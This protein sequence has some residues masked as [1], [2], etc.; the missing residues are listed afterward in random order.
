M[1][2]ASTTP[3]GRHLAVR[4]LSSVT[5]YGHV[6]GYGHNGS[7]AKQMS[8]RIEG[9]SSE[10][11]KIHPFILLS[12]DHVHMKDPAD[13]FRRASSAGSCTSRASAPGSCGIS[14]IGRGFLF[15]PIPSVLSF[16]RG[17]PN[18][19][20]LADWASRCLEKRMHLSQITKS[21]VLTSGLLLSFWI[22]PNLC[23]IDRR[24]YET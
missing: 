22:G 7:S 21:G 12:Y 8:R 2:E 20:R 17:K 9:R 19:F 4:G 18:L 24:Q 3:T 5:I 1:L 23:P 16:E 15:R 13:H 14:G 10:D 11:L 6:T